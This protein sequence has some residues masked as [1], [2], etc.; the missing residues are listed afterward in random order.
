M[1]HPGETVV[2]NFDIPFAK[3]SI[4]L[5]LV[6]Y[7]QD[8]RIVL[9]RTITSADDVFTEY[10]K[11]YDPTKVYKE[12]DRCL[13]ET[14]PYVRKSWGED[15]PAPEAWTPDHWTVSDKFMTKFY[16]T[17]SQEESLLFEDN[18]DFKIQLNV[19][20]TSGSRCVCHEI[21]GSNGV[22]HHR[23]VISDG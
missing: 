8:G 22:Q 20:T 23:E 3:S 10:E 9:E 18:R 6:T 5:I 11:E 21:K 16:V 17:L 19:L 4:S 14:A 12:N 2:H 13:Y 1:F 7:K 15:T